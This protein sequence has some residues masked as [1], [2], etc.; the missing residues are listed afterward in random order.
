MEREVLL[1]VVREGSPDKVTFK[2]ETKRKIQGKACSYL[3]QEHSRKR[4]GR[5]QALGR[6]CSLTLL[7]PMCPQSLC[8]CT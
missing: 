4:A 2:Q 7:E 1:R 5:C 6:I 8:R 3:G